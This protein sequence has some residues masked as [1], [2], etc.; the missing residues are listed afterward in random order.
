MLPPRTSIWICGGG[1]LPRKL[2]GLKDPVLFPFGDARW[3]YLVFVGFI[4]LL[5]VLDL[6]VFHKKNHVIAAKEALLWSVFWIGLA[7]AFNLAL[8]LSLPNILEKSA[9]VAE[10]LPGADMK[11]VAGDL[12]AKFLTGYLIELSLS[13]DNLF[14]FVVVFSYFA[15]PATLQHRILFFGILGA[16]VFRALFIAVG[17]LLM[18]FT[19]VVIL[20][21]LFLIYTGVKLCIKSEE[22]LDPEK[23]PL[24]R[25]FRRFVPVT[26]TF[27]GQKFFIIQAGKRYATPL[28]VAL[29]VVEMTDIVFAID[30]VPAI[31]SITSEPLIVFTSNMFAILG[32]RTLYFLLANAVDKFHLLKYGLGIILV[33]VGVK[34]SFLHYFNVKV[35]T[36]LSLGVVL[37]VLALSMVLSF[38]IP[39]KHE[40]PPAAPAG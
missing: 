3:F 31:F 15:I 32:L 7:L 12:A 1:S 10:L 36:E 2:R 39:K 30:S 24:I 34:M 18:R 27:D 17:A 11:K 19:S 33:F 38:V 25:L 4:T 5:L 6:K 37:G 23:N 26:P 21:G 29:L 28:F 40:A 22:K 35:P 9:R 14:V 16:I 20:M 8:Y 13:V